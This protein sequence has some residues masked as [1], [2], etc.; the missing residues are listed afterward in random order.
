MIASLVFSVYN[1]Q[2]EDGG[3]EMMTFD[4]HVPYY[5]GAPGGGLK[6]W[7][8]LQFFQEA[9]TFHASSLG[10][11][12][13]DLRERGFTWVLR[14]YRITLHRAAMSDDVAVRT[15]YEPHKNLLS[16]RM[17]ELNDASG[18]LCASA[19]S[20][21]LVLDLASGRPLPLDRGLPQAYF[22]NTDPVNDTDPPKMRVSECA[23][24]RSYRA[25]MSELDANRHTNHTVYLDWALDSVPDDVAETMQ[26]VYIDAE[27]VRSVQRDSVVSAVRRVDDPSGAAF[28]HQMKTE[29]GQEVFRAKTV[30]GEL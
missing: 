15:W 12:V 18:A 28:E 17:F 7:Q 29:E 2:I 25:R 20:G 30:W 27:Y 8:M 26:P 23:D 4:M 16:V 22:D 3:R 5:G 9:A 24:V 10:A 21:W 13:H 1:A 6:V 19:W 14:R 11:G